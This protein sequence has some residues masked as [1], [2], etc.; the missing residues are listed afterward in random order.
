MYERASC[1]DVAFGFR[2]FAAECD[3]LVALATQ[4]PGRAPSS[5]LELA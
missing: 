2:D 1:Y 5:V 3:A 4:H